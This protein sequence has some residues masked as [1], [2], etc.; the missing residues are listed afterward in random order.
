VVPHPATLALQRACRRRHKLLIAATAP[1]AMT[2][3]TA[4]RQVTRGP[5]LSN[6]C[7]D[8]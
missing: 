1:T 3:L 6:A 2:S 5:S 7:A 8:A 4:N